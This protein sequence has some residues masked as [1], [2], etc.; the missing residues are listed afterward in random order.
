[1]AYA[2]ASGGNLEDFSGKNQ[3]AASFDRFTAALVYCVR[4]NSLSHSFDA[5]ADIAS[6][7][8]LLCTAHGTAWPV[9]WS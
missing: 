2:V 8:R 5:A 1:M 7:C 9:P 4:G 3:D 6:F